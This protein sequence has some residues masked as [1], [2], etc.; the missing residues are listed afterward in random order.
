[1]QQIRY[2]KKAQE[3][4]YKIALTQTLQRSSQEEMKGTEMG[5][6]VTLKLLYS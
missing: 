3:K 1:M 2:M 6:Q 4:V 5:R